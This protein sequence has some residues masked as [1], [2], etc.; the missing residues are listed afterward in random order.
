M[1]LKERFSLNEKKISLHRFGDFPCKSYDII[2]SGI[3][4]KIIYLLQKISNMLTLYRN[5]FI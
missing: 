2:Q 5:L 4:F 3:R 1:L